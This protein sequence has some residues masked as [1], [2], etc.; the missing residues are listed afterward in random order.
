MKEVVKG[1][2]E[3][4][5]TRGRRRIELL[6][7]LK[8]R[9][10]KN[11]KSNAPDRKQWKKTQL[12]QRTRK[13]AGHRRWRWW[14]PTCLVEHTQG[15][16]LSNV[17]VS[18]LSFQFDPRI[19]SYSRWYHFTSRSERLHYNVNRSLGLII[20][21]R[22]R[23]GAKVEIV[24]HHLISALWTIVKHSHIRTWS[25]RWGFRGKRS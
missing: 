10:F 25:E 2:M 14:W 18:A 6:D 11:L 20:C 21:R 19:E 13:H 5:K 23:Q 4:E 16:V 7:Y 12:T 17:M 1:T 9:G 22:K 3:G 24:T 15:N 8:Y